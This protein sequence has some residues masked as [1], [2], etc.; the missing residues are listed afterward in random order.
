MRAVLLAFSPFSRLVC[1]AKD[2]LYG[3]G[4]LRAARAPLPVASVGNLAF[5]GTGKTPLAM[6]LIDRL[7]RMGHRPAFVSRG[8]RGAWERS[9]GILSDGN[10][11]LGTWQDGGDEPFMVA[12][13]LPKT[14]VFVGKDR[15]A[16]CLRAKDLGFTAI[17]L[18][19][20]FQHRRLARD[21]DV[22]LVDPAG[23][24]PLRE[25]PAALARADIILVRDGEPAI[26]ERL[27][28]AFPRASVFGYKAV[29]RALIE[30]A[31]GAE[32]RLEAL[33]GQR[34]LA[35]CGIAGPERFLASLRDLGLDVAG[36]LAFPDHHAYPPESLRRIAD[37]FAASGAARIV[38]TEKDAVKLAPAG[39]PLDGAPLAF[40]RI[41]LDI[42]AGFLERFEALFPKPGGPAA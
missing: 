36:S 38:T 13:R 24:R 14:G 17:V 19:D 42:E 27:R 39:T 32:H 7:A 22:V 25:G 1:R 5:G 20:A 2:R 29:P 21:L 18:D 9:G 11:L 8:Y 26:L 12:S 10:D 6:E 28:S 35:F 41:G 34:V 33:K 37:A 23:R 15:L 31:T 4:L 30:P 16:S 40:L 3:R